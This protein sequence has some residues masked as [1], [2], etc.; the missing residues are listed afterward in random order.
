MVACYMAQRVYIA[1]THMPKP[2][3]TLTINSNNCLYYNFI[4]YI[5]DPLIL[6]SQSQSEN[7]SSS[8]IN[9]ILKL[10]LNNILTI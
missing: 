9:I 8:L 5:L 1:Y 2:F 4:I 10:N 3:F 6:T 7:Y